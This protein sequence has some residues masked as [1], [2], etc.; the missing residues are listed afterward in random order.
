MK[1]SKRITLLV[2][3]TLVAVVLAYAGWTRLR[4]PLSSAKEDS[5]HLWI[6]LTKNFEGDVRYVGGDDT[7]SYFRVGRVFWTYLK[8]RHCA[9]KIPLTFP[10]QSGKSYVVR[11]HTDANNAMQGFDTCERHEDFPLGQLDRVDQDDA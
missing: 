2:L 8:I 3:A 1:R 10:V 4:S 6:A 7:Y 9:A 11:R 5:Y